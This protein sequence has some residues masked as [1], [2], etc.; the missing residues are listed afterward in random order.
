MGL[1]WASLHFVKGGPIHYSLLQ[2]NANVDR[3]SDCWI[4][5]KRPTIWTWTLKWTGDNSLT[6]HISKYNSC[7]TTESTAMKNKTSYK[8]FVYFTDEWREEKSNSITRWKTIRATHS[9]NLLMLCFHGN[10]SFVN[11]TVIC[12]LKNTC[13]AVSSDNS[14]FFFGIWVLLQIVFLAVFQN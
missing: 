5:N 12:S 11:K 6:C 7:I 1:V 14:R 10:Q 4:K 3:P 8:L 13:T 9:G 2:T